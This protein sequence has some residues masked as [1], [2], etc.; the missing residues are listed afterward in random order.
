LKICVI[1]K[2]VLFVG[3]VELELLRKHLLESLFKKIQISSYT[4]NLLFRHAHNHKIHANKP[5]RFSKPEAGKIKRCKSNPQNAKPKT[6]CN[7]LNYERLRI[8][9]FDAKK[10]QL[11]VGIN[12]F[13]SH[14][15]L[16]LARLVFDCCSYCW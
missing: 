10:A 13:T 15:I 4:L 6:S 11:A 5:D 3:T 1:L 16:P 2:I 9:L 14:L 7:K 12:M 8:E